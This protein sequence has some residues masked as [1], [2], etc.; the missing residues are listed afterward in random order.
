[1][2]PMKYDLGFCIPEGGILHSHRR[3]HMKLLVL[4]DL[5]GLT[6]VSLSE[7]SA[8]EWSQHLETV[9]ILY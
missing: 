1:M 5:C 9:P 6:R 8:E 7:Y 3:S 4:F 2:F